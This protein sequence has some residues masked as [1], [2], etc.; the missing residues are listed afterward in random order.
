MNNTLRWL[1]S[2]RTLMIG[3]PIGLAVMVVLTVL[4]RTSASGAS[5]G[6]VLVCSRESVP[7]PTFPKVLTTF[8]IEPIPVFL[9]FW[10]AMGY[11]ICFRTVRRRASSRRFS[12]WR[13]VSFL[14]GILLVLGTVFGPLSAYDGTFLSIHMIQHFI[15]ITIAP[16]LLLAGA[17]LTLFLI[18]IGKKARERTVYPIT[19]SGPFHAITHPI[20]GVA[21]FLLVPAAWYVTPAFRLA[22]DHEWLHWFAYVLFLF[23]GIH[24]WWPVVGAN[25]TRWN[26]PHPVRVMYLFALVPIHAFLG[27]LFYSPERVLYPELSEVARTWGPSPLL[28]QQFAGM[29]MMVLGELIGLIALLVAANEWANADQRQATRYDRAA[30]RRPAPENPRETS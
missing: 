1:P 17:P 9:L 21:L 30:H 19:H 26:L 25:P 27:I 10:V 5:V 13:A 16:P 20:V 18:T 29:L 23:A 15:L 24:Y 2:G 22:L 14:V 4:L 7:A 28:D 3:L 11:L 8:A 6:W 12:G